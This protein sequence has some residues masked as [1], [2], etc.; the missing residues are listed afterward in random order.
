[1]HSVCF[2][3]ISVQ[4]WTVLV[5]CWFKT[6]EFPSKIAISSSEFQRQI[7]LRKLTRFV[8]PLWVFD[9]RL[10]CFV[11]SSL[12]LCLSCSVPLRPLVGLRPPSNFFIHSLSTCFVQDTTPAGVLSSCGCHE[13]SDQS[14]SSQ[15]YMAWC[16]C[17][18]IL[19]ALCYPQEAFCPDQ[20]S[21]NETEI[22]PL[23]YKRNAQ[24]DS[25]TRIGDTKNKSWWLK[26][27][28]PVPVN[29]G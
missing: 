24:S 20:K 23:D 8:P 27:T 5:D 18:E 22:F 1:M 4:P 12:H 15:G 3:P 6:E 19:I 25:E 21:L 29:V 16:G 10:S 14:R 17:H 13:K 11:C 2:S 9:H 28:V 26:G 7:I